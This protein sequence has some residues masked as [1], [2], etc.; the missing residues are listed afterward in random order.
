MNAQQPKSNQTKKR[1]PPCIPL[2]RIFHSLV[3]VYLSLIKLCS[4]PIN[5]Q[6]I[7]R[8]AELQRVPCT[9]IPALIIRY[10][11]C[12]GRE[13]VPAETLTRVLRPKDLIS[14]TRRRALLHREG[15]IRQVLPR[16]HSCRAG[17]RVAGIVRPSWD[18]SVAGPLA[19]A[20]E[21]RQPVAGAAHLGT[22]A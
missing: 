21:K 1:R 19:V 5:A 10:L 20:L 15:R 22:V 7:P 2:P 3:Y 14:L 17:I 13:R 18:S 8:P 12:R 4:R 11:G 6:P 16:Q 9:D